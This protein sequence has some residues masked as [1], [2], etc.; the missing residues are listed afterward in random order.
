[1]HKKNL[2]KLAS[3]IGEK[4]MQGIFK[5]LDSQD[6]SPQEFIIA[7]FHIMAG[8]NMAFFSLV[9]GATDLPI[10]TIKG[11]FDSLVVKFIKTYQELTTH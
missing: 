7:F 6:L 5:E 10:S 9:S 4:H 2:H 3:H 11:D 8:M 1:M